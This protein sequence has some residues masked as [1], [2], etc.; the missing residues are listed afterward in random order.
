MFGRMESYMKN[1]KYEFFT[2]S[3]LKANG[4]MRN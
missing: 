3:E 2:T 1:F 4:W